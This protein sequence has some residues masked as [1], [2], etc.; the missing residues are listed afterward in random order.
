MK[1]EI[2]VFMVQNEKLNWIIETEGLINWITE[3][4]IFEE[5]II[6]CCV[7]HFPKRIFSRMLVLLLGAL[8]VA[9]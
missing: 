3:T 2:P 5:D 9:R 1:G 8:V 7:K 4:N 6:M